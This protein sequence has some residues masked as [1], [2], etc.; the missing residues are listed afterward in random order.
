MT[1]SGDARRVVTAN[2]EPGTPATYTRGPG[3]YVEGDED[4]DDVL[5]SHKDEDDRSVREYGQEAGARDLR[6][7]VRLVRLY[8]KAG[9]AGDG[10]RACALI[11]RPIAKSRDFASV[12]PKAYASVSGSSL[13]SDKSCAEVE[14]VLF[15]LNRRTLLAGVGDVTVASL[16][17][18]GDHG[19]ALLA[20]KTM[21]E[22]EIAVEREHGRWRIDALLDGEI[23]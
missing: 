18:K 19:I 8:Y 21:P 15:E 5:H 9:V 23:V 13:F 20:F 17:V 4:S 11:Y 14:S 16:R 22:R 6:T 12:V 2:P 10:A 3:G 7:V 1:S